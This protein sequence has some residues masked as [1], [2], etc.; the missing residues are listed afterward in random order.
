VECEHFLEC[1][2][3]RQPSL[4]DGRN[5]V[6]VVRVIEAAQRSLQANGQEVAITRTPIPSSTEVRD[7][8]WLRE[9]KGRHDAE[10]DAF[11]DLTVEEKLPAAE[12]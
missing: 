6:Q 1:V 9:A 5:G 2:T 4:T 10:G 11:V 3:R 12:G 7:V 8:V